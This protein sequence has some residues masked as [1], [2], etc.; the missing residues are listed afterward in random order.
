M[1]HWI[2]DE[3]GLEGRL[4]KCSHCGASYYDIFTN[5]NTAES[6][7]ACGESIDGDKNEYV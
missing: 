4:Y 7:P 1:A 3:H 2:I 6:C 5:V